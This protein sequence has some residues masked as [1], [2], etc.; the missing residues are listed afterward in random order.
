MSRLINN[1]EKFDIFYYDALDS[2]D[3]E[4]YKDVRDKLY[5]D[6]VEDEQGY[7]ICREGI[8]K[9]YIEDI[10]NYEK[11]KGIILINKISQYIVGFMLFTIHK[12][13]INLKLIGTVEDDNERLG[14]KIGSMFLELLEKYAKSKNIFLIKSDVVK[15][16]FD[17]YIKNGYIEKGR[18][19]NGIKCVEKDLNH[20]KYEIKKIFTR[21]QILEEI[22]TDEE[23]EYDTD[24]YE[25]PYETSKKDEDIEINNEE[26]K[27]DDTGE[28]HIDLNLY[29]QFEKIK[30]KKMDI[31]SDSDM[32]TE[33]GI[34]NKN[35]L[36]E[37]VY[38]Y[39]INTDEYE[40]N[41]CCIN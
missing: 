12:E 3:D 16:A 29:S 14:M 2:D 27:E 20:E 5:D 9:K 28:I 21:H 13:Y 26:E 19:T 22:C 25:E 41:K 32:I 7:Y 18:K 1:L 31:D 37:E 30:L 8:E 11:I 17:F 10:F 24:T 36:K 33:N 23:E 6:I 34:D 4:L 38:D 39:D 40:K 15:E 35:N